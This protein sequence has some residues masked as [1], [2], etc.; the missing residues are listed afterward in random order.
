MNNT[1][2][3]LPPYAKVSI[4]AERIDPLFGLLRECGLPPLVA[5]GLGSS[6]N[7]NGGKWFTVRNDAGASSAEILI[8]G[9]IGKDWWSDDGVS[10][11]EFL[12]ALKAIP[13]NREI[14]VGI[15]SEGGEIKCGLGIYNALQQRRDKV[16]CRIDGYAVS[17][18]SVIALAGKRTISPKSSIWMIHEPWT[19]AQGNAE[20]FLRSAEMLEQH[21]AMLVDIYAEHTGKTKDEIRAAMKKE[22]W[23]RGAEALEFGLCDE[24]PDDPEEM[25]LKNGFDLKRL[26]NAPEYVKNFAVRNGAPVSVKNNPPAPSDEAN[27]QEHMTREE[28]IAALK[29]RGDE[30]DDKSTTEQLKAQLMAAPKAKA[31]TPPPAQNGNDALAQELAAIRAERQAEKKARITEKVKALQPNRFPV[32]QVD[33]W[34]NDA[35]RDEAVLDRLAALPEQAPGAEPVT[36]DV[37]SEDPRELSKAIKSLWGV[38]NFSPEAARDRG[39]RRA[40]IIAKN[41]DRLVLAASTSTHTVDATLKLNLIL[42]QAIR[43]FARRL[44]PVGIFSTRLNAV[45]LLGTDKVEVPYF[46]LETAASTDFV[47]GNGYDTFSNTSTDNRE[48]TIDKRKYQ[49]ISWTSSEISRQPYLSIAQHTALKAE[50]L[51]YDVWTDVLGVVTVAN[52]GAAVVTQPAA[53]WNSDTFKSI[54]LAADQAQWPQVGRSV[55]VDATIHAQLLT[56]DAI[57]AALNYGGTEGIRKGTIPELFGFDYMSNANIPSNSEN[58]NGFTAFKSAALFAQAPIE[59]TNEVLSQLSQYEVVVDPEVGV[60]MEYRLWGDPDMD[61]SKRVIECNYGYAAG[62]AAALKRFVSA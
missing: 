49:G 36:V 29:A 24:C 35:M 10:E 47:A 51:A 22:T 30:V 34:V 21:A 12:D 57:K 14:V 58:L 2:I 13:A 1:R 39:M 4:D 32:A 31:Q 11:R 46:A 38:K 44:F 16:T 55:V 41:R 62:E 42:D 40:S 59:P 33:G 18:A 17:I 8:H 19:Y 23:L 53:A 15:N 25:D 6:P 45:P 61:T 3:S 56:D 20:D 48:V 43:A 9:Q 5:V 52:Y 50:K 54:I 27:T 26:K 60:S 7:T 28:I 37:Q